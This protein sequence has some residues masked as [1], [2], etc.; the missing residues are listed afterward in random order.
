M[1]KISNWKYLI[2]YLILITLAEITVAYVNPQT[3]VIF[4]IIIL[5]ILF[6]HSGY[7]SKEKMSLNEL[8]WLYIENYKK[9]SRSI[10]KSINEITKILTVLISLTLAPLIR[11]LSLVMPL[12]NFPRIQWFTIISVALYLSIFIV[13]QQQ[14][15]TLT[16]Y[17]FRWPK[18]KHI[19][20]EIGI[21][22]LAIPFGVMEYL[23]LHPAPL[24]S[25]FS[26]ENILVAVLILFIATGLIEEIIFR[27]ILQKKTMN[28]M[29]AWQGMLFVTILFAML[30]IG[31][32][33]FLDVLL[34][35]FIG[36]L[37]SLVVN[38]TKTIIGVTASHTVVNIMLF[39]VC[40][41]IMF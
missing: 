37:Y 22:L 29:G 19:P 17:G 16:E 12:A 41:F 20:T 10:Q 38:K 26:V 32:L 4:H 31:N 5:S 18:R 6:I 35:F 34:V 23:I 36:G 1:H 9:P 40:P 7:A 25:S 11:V 33:S 3:G 30:H 14:K 24:V 15:I 2:I 27:G 28:I 21:V 13:I 8:Q 39:I